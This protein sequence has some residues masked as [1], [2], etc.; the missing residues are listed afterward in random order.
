MERKG[1]DSS[2]TVRGDLA[3]S[4]DTDVPP[5]FIVRPP[6]RLRMAGSDPRARLTRVNAPAKAR[7]SAPHF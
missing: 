5:R 7:P 2:Q 4:V 1:D 6:A 3:T